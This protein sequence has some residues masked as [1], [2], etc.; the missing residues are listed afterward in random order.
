MTYNMLIFVVCNTF[1]II[2]EDHVFN[3]KLV[4]LKI[5]FF[6]RMNLTGLR[7]IPEDYEL[8]TCDC[9]H[10]FILCDIGGTSI[11]D[12]DLIKWGLIVRVHL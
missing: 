2:A 8:A 6:I 7:L 10:S 12:G 1:K 3:T 5:R 9:N 4:V 11:F